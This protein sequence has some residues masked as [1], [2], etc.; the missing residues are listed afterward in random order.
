MDLSPFPQIQTFMD[1]VVLP[2]FVDLKAQLTT[3]DKSITVVTNAESETEAVAAVVRQMHSETPYLAS[4]QNLSSPAHTWIV[5]SLYIEILQH[6]ETEPACIGQY[7]LS[8]EIRIDP[9][10]PIEVTF[11]VGHRT[12]K[13]SLETQRKVFEDN[14]QRLEIED[15][16]RSDIIEHFVENFYA[17][18]SQHLESASP[19]LGSPETA[20]IAPNLDSNELNLTQPN[21]ETSPPILDEAQPK[22]TPFIDPQTLYDLSKQLTQTLSP[23]GFSITSKFNPKLQNS[24]QINPIQDRY[25]R[26]IDLGLEYSP[27][28]TETELTEY[29]HRLGHYQ[30]LKHLAHLHIFIQEHMQAW[31]KQHGQPSLGAIAPHLNQQI[32]ELRERLYHHIQ[33]LTD[34]KLDSTAQTLQTEV[35]TLSI[36]Q[37]QQQTLLNQLDQNPLWGYLDTHLLNLHN[38][39]K[40]L[41]QPFTNPN[42][43]ID[44]PAQHVTTKTDKPI[45]SHIASCNSEKYK[46]YQRKRERSDL[47]HIIKYTITQKLYPQR[48][49]FIGAAP[50]P[51][52]PRVEML[53]G[54]NDESAAIA[55]SLTQIWCIYPMMRTDPP[56]WLVVAATTDTQPLKTIALE[57]GQIAEEGSLEYLRRSLHL[58]FQSEDPHTLNLSKLVTEALECR[59]IKYLHIHQ[60][61]DCETS[62][63]RDILQMQFRLVPTDSR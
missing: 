1:A 37:Q 4:S 24:A 46:A 19:P 31:F 30:T 35:H 48:P 28:I 58:M 45:L 38:Q 14:H 11:I 8:I 53:W 17:F 40:E 16:L 2:T 3:L 47:K 55:N 23:S 49:V 56:Q 13:K 54:E 42:Q 10:E 22:P 32:A 62:T 33:T 27:A 57:N 36:H 7:C 50:K 52:Y 44:I 60:T 39:L 41:I 18:K 25:M 34:R 63:A 29:L 59:R 9:L 43:S 12:G 26:T 21:P 6:I 61:E 51:V 15:I 5:A 20:S